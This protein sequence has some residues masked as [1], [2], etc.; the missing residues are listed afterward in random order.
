MQSLR[1]AKTSSKCSG[2]HLASK[3]AGK[4]VAKDEE[5]R[6]NIEPCHLGDCNRHE[7][8][9]HDPLSRSQQQGQRPSVRGCVTSLEDTS[10]AQTGPVGQS[11]ACG[12]G[13]VGVK[14]MLND[15]TRRFSNAVW[16]SSGSRLRGSLLNSGAGVS[17]YGASTPATPT[18]ALS[19][20]CKH[21]HA[22]DTSNDNLSEGSSNHTTQCQDDARDN[23]SNDGQAYV[24]TRGCQ[25]HASEQG[26]LAGERG[27]D[28]SGSL[29]GAELGK[30]N[31]P[32]GPAT[33]ASLLT[34]LNLALVEKRRR[35]ESAY[36][37]SQPHPLQK[38]APAKD[39][40]T[41][42]PVR[43]NFVKLQHFKRKK[44]KGRGSKSGGRYGMGGQKLGG[45]GHRFAKG[46]FRKSTCYVCG[47]AG[48]W[49]QECPQNGG[50]GATKDARV[51]GVDS[52]VC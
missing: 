26:T 33:E 19:A 21:T 43:E 12:I 47:K 30:R 45:G 28:E 34:D 5:M 51:K 32:P 16:L 9:H 10:D 39:S 20:D 41:G 27:A 35:L 4:L 24:H 49:A 7:E 48:H 25:G 42:A 2:A 46:K 36:Y 37:Q 8:A 44:Y 3:A 31:P 23:S 15:S 11:E 29:E 52:L 38:K 13:D 14:K 40:A 18:Q 6:E 22:L 1:K 17:R 50:D